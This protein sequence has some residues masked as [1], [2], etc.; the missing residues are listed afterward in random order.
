MKPFYRL[1]GL[2]PDISALR[3]PVDCR[4]RSTDMVSYT[5]LRQ[6]HIYEFSQHFLNSHLF[7]NADSH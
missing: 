1:P 4:L 6:P 2:V 7:T 5:P 3:C